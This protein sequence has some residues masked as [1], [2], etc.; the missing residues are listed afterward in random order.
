MIGGAPTFSGSGAGA[1][2]A[3]AGE[4]GINWRNPAAWSVAVAYSARDAVTDGGASFVALAD[5]PAGG[6]RPR[7]DAANWLMIGN[8]GGQIAYSEVVA[9]VPITPQATAVDTGC[10]IVVPARSGP[11]ALE[12]L[13]NAAQIS[14]GAAAVANETVLLRMLI[15]D[16]AGICVAHALWRQVIKGANE[17]RFKP[18][19]VSR[20]NL[21]DNA[22]DKTYKLQGY[23][24]N[25]NA[26][27]ETANFWAGSGAQTVAQ[28]VGNT[29]VGPMS[30]RAVAA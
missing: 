18:L 2:S 24:D 9:T 8:A 26:G 27:H 7:A 20:A 21:P 30:L 16:E 29:N 22:A 17:N 12:G 4:P 15:V 13:C 1:T 10:Q 25:L 28:S 14:A 6:A 23:V 19:R 5:V 11:I 3:G